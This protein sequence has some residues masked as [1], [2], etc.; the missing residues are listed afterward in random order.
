MSEHD[1]AAK[2]ARQVA[3]LQAEIAAL[4]ELYADR[5]RDLAFEYA[6]AEAA[7]GALADMQANWLSPSEAAG[8]QTEHARLLTGLR[9]AKLAASIQ[10]ARVSNGFVVRGEWHRL[11]E[12][13]QAVIDGPAYVAPDVI[14]E[15]ALEAR[16][17]TP[18]GVMLFGEVQG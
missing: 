14:Y 11:A 17:G 16:A 4:R 3:D 7:E 18:R 13:L 15:A 1:I 10:A 8:L 5:E 9:G 2:C 12:Q 6:R